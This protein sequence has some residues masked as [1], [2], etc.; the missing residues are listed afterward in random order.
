[1]VVKRSG[2]I[3][4]TPMKARQAEPGPSILMLLAVSV[5][6]AVLAMA[7]VWFVFFRT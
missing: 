1:M 7:A 4:E 5:T 6:I 3:V 2:V